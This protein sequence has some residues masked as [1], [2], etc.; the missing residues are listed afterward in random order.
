MKNTALPRIYVIL[1]VLTMN[2]ACDQRP[3]PVSKAGTITMLQTPAA[4]GSMG[5]NLIAGEDGTIV[6]SWIEP[7]DEGNALRHARFEDGAWSD[8]RMVVSGENWFVNWADF[9]SV[10]PV[11]ESLWAAH[12]LVSTEEY[13]YA[14]DLRTAISEDAGD[15]WSD[16]KTPHTDGIDTEHGFATIFSDQGEIGI[17]W[18]DGRK[19]I[20]DFDENDVGASGMT[21]RFAN[22][23]NQMT[24]SNDA[25]V[26]DLTCDCCQTDVAVT[27]D[28]PVAIYRDRSVKE[29][30]DIYVS[31]RVDG[32]WQPGYAVNADNWDI[33]AC[34]VNGPVIQAN[35]RKV[36]VAWFTG[37]NDE[38][39]VKVAWSDDAGRTFSDPM[40]VDADHPLGH[41]GAAMLANGD[42][43]LSWLRS[44]GLG[45]AHVLL[46]R[47]SRNGVQSEDF[48]LDEA[49]DVFAFSVPQI[50][51]DG[52][53]LLVAWTTE[54]EG[55]YGVASALVPT[56]VL[57]S[58]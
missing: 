28:G 51:R 58:R 18:L 57:D 8:P 38:P 2:A 6:L 27:S 41:V 14:Y 20:N 24:V 35:G 15:T 21:L 31:R 13:G 50:T 56:A 30:R 19:Y 34:P 22:I 25:L 45:G 33:A 37:A 4:E 16:W 26:D 43:A 54:I 12:W 55:T 5:P 11:S 36:A 42:L 46:K 7:H 44:T 17:L 32:E 29:I 3:G 49:A 52:D 40:E 1:A 39:R 23:D 48:I 53:N 9:P 10:V 47:I